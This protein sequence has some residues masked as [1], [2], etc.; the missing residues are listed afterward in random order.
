MAGRQ[1]TTG[2]VPGILVGQHDRV[3]LNGTFRVYCGGRTRRRWWKQKSS[4]TSTQN[5][6]KEQK[7]GGGVDLLYSEKFPNYKEAT[8]FLGYGVIVEVKWKKTW[9]KGHTGYRCSE[10]L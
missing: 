5:K 8:E 1:G 3:D 9:H 4:I 6:E 7:T 2:C 10:P